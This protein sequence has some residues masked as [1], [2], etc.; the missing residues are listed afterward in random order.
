[1]KSEVTSGVLCSAL[2]ASEL[3]SL[4][5][6]MMASCCNQASTRCLAKRKL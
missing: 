4:A 6:T 3:R 1:M 2:M 5:L